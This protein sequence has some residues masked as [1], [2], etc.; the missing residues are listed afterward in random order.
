MDLSMLGSLWRGVECV[1]EGAVDFQFREGKLPEVAEAGIAG[2]KVI[3]GDGT[4]HAAQGIELREYQFLI[5]E[6]VPSVISISSR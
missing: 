4:A 6:K 1:N 2:A 5:L 3:K